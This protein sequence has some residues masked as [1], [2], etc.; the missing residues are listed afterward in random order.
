[1]FYVL[2]V[3]IMG[4]E[5]GFMG[6]NRKYLVAVVVLAVLAVVFGLAGTVAPVELV[7]PQQSTS[8]SSDPLTHFMNPPTYD[9]D[10]VNITDK[11]GESFTLTHDLISVHPVPEEETLVD[12]VGRRSLA[13]GNHKLFF[14]STYMQVWNRTYGGIEWDDAWSVVETDDGGYALAGVTDSFGAG[15]GDFWLV[16]TDSSGNVEWN[17]TY[18]GPMGEEAHSVVET[19][20]GGFAL[21]GFTDSFGAGVTDLWLVKTG[22]ESGFSIGLSMIDFTYSNITFYRGSDDPYWN[23]LRVRIWIFLEPT[24][25]FGDINQDGIV[26]A[27]DLYI[28]SQNYGKTFSLLSLTGILA[29]TGI[30]TYKKRKKQPE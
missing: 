7:S 19:S 27:Q 8:S 12:V 9:S 6:V 28:V 24:W 13:G 10:W 29:I 5:S 23:Y 15:L 16:K 26:D 4:L 11:R 17:Q 25:M 21:A 30:Y 14:G 3:I 1:M 22:E 18:G 2:L 20:D